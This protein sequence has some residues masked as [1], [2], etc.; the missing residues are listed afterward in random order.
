MKKSVIFLL[1]VSLLCALPFSLSAAA[2]R[3]TNDEH[4]AAVDIPDGYTVLTTDNLKKQS[5]LLA[6]LG[7]SPTSFK[8]Y[9][10][11]AG[12]FLCAL[13]DTNTTQIQLKSGETDFTAQIGN[14]ATLDEQALSDAMSTLVAKDSGDALIDSAQ[15]TKGGV[16]YF[17]MTVKV[18]DKQKD[19][20]YKQYVTVLNGSL[21][22]L[23]Y[24]NFDGEFSAGQSAEAENIF[25]SLSLTEKKGFALPGGNMFILIII[26]SVV[27]LA[28]AIVTVLLIISFIKDIM[29]KR[30]ETGDVIEHVRIKRR[31]F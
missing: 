2:A 13:N 18:T 6:K 15:V 12:I 5:E 21:Y 3:V 25:K 1:I 4:R 27:I 24:Y 8:K 14:L 29:R 26:V 30:R 28:A 19:F 10:Q 16:L 9:M 31:R 20:C 23:V 7:H 17:A 11:D 22:S